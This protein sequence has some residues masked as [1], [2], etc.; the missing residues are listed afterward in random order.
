MT[1]LID[2]NVFV[3]AKN[4]YYG[5]DIAPGFWDWL[6]SAQT[7]GLIA[8]VKRVR[9]EIEDGND[10]LASWAKALPSTFAIDV[11]D[12]DIAHLANLS[13]W[14]NSS[15]FT[16]AAVSEF[17]SSA[18]YFLVAQARG[19]EC[20]VVTQEVWSNGHTKVKIPNACHAI[21]VECISTF[22]LLRREGVRLRH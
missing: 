1:Y 9:D 4:R 3:E 13:Q 20:T 12:A 17:L 6:E 14:A 21:S 22:E 11:E 18:D 5:F 2:A 15:G 19:Q 8:T 7:D 16:P 10:D